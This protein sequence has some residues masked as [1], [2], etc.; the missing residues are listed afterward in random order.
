MHNDLILVR[1]SQGDKALREGSSS[2]THKQRIA[3]R[4]ADGVKTV[5]DI[6]SFAGEERTVNSWYELI[7]AN[8]LQPKDMNVPP[9]SEYAG[10]KYKLLSVIM[11]NLNDK[12]SATLKI[13]NNL[14][15]TPEGISETLRK[16]ERLVRMTIDEDI[17]A[18]LSYRMREALS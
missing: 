5:S 13:V 14:E 12:A 8:H 6:Q 10:I 4:L 9:F 11:C 3:L 15:E 17:V 2:L 18:Q 7:K 1:T 16:V